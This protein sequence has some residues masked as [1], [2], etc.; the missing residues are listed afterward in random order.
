MKYSIVT[1]GCQMNVS[2]SERI[3]TFLNSL[4]HRK[5]DQKPDLFIVNMCSVRQSAVNR[6][7]ALEKK[8][9]QFR[10]SNK[11]FTAILT[12]CF[13]KKDKEKLK[14]IFDYL[15]KTNELFSFFEKKEASFFKI[16]PE[17]RE[18][19]FIGLIPISQGCNFSCSYCVVPFT[20]GK[21]VCRKP[22][23]ILR[24][25]EEMIKKGVKEIWLLGQNVNDYHYLQFDFEDLIKEINQLE[26]KFW[27]RINSPHPMNFS[28]KIIDI[29]ARSQ[30][31]TPYL[32]LP[33]QSGDDFI[34]KKMKRNY[35]V[36]DYKKL[37]KKIKTAFK[38][39][40]QGLEKN[41]AISTDIIVGFP[42]EKERNFE[43]TKRVINEIKFDNIYLAKFSP[44]AN[45]LAE[46]MENQ[47]SEKEK[48]KRYQELM[49][50]A[51]KISFQK[52]LKFFN[53]KISV[54]IIEEKKG[55]L[56]GKSRHFKT[57]KLKGDP[58]LVGNFVKARI[59]AVKDFGLTAELIK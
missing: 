35:T 28:D 27:L 37:I 4:G 51:S 55:F 57:V 30:K 52:N 7:F 31:F 49:K 26:G 46:K 10:K 53:K 11:N 19:K 42:E 3:E 16:F 2:D 47:I 59:V 24:E 48:E 54:L 17:I 36:S 20:R 1:F 33:L 32:N 14:K 58:S 21:L 23:E 45:T 50:L 12:G 39:Y 6:V 41:I 44:R 9:S 13:L 18:K 5:D 25:I 15:L 56:F 40:R 8:I 43:N 34:L 22:D 29:L 38:K